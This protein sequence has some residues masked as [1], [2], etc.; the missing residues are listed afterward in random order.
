MGVFLTHQRPNGCFQIQTHGK[1]TRCAKDLRD[2]R[3]HCDSH[4]AFYEVGFFASVAFAN[5]QGFEQFLP[6]AYA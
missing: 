4:A 5:L 2:A 1:Y 3:R 6:A